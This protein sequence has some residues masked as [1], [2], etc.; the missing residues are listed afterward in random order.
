[1]II[2]APY[3][4]YKVESI[5][6]THITVG[7]RNPAESKDLIWDRVSMRVIGGIGYPIEHLV[8]MPLSVVKAMLDDA[9]WSYKERRQ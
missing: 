6:L 2:T 1:M 7:A 9:I 3:S 5:E 4:I 8:R